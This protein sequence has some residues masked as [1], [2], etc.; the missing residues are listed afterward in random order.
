MIITVVVVEMED[1][2]TEKNPQVPVGF[3]VCLKFARFSRRSAPIA[4]W[5]W[6]AVHWNG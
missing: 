1:D 5:G 6:A 2:G 3:S 4:K